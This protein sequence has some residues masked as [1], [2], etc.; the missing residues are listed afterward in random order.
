[1]SNSVTELDITIVSLRSGNHFNLE[2]IVSNP[3]M[4]PMFNEAGFTTVT[5]LAGMATFMFAY[6]AELKGKLP[7]VATLVDRVLR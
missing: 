7:V 6:P 2:K 5:V 1:M 4:V 3:L